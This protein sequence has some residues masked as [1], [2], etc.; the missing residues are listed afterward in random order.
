[1]LS[2]RPALL[3][4]FLA[5]VSALPACGEDASDALEGQQ[6]Q[7]WE[8]VPPGKADDYYSNVS[9][10]FEVSGLVQV[11]LDPARAEDTE[12]R[13]D[14]IER[15]ITAVSLFLTTYMTRKLEQFFSNTTYGG[16]GAM[17]RN[18]TVAAEDV[19]ELEPGL[20][21]V[22]FTVDVAGPR[23]LVDALPLV[24][25]SEEG[26]KAFVL[27]MPKGFEVDPDSVPRGQI[28]NFDPS[29]YAGEV[30]QLICDIEP[31]VAARDAYPQFAAM[32]EDGLLDLTLWY[33]HDYNES[34]SDLSEARDAFDELELLGFEAPVADFESLTPESGPFV[35][36]MSAGGQ[37]LQVEVRIFHS[38][39][40][41]GRRQDA[42]D[43]SLSELGLRDV[44]FYNG[45]AGPYY[46]FYLSTES[47]YDVRYQEFATV[48]LPEKQQIVVAQ[49]CQTYSQYADVFYANPAKSEANLDVFTTVNF[50]Y[51]QGTLG[52]LRNLLAADRD[53]RHKPTTYGKMVRDLNSE[54]WN[55]V[56]EV[57]YGV[58]GIDQNPRLHPYAAQ[59][60]IGRP[61]STVADCGDPYGNVCVPQGD[62]AEG[63]VCG[64]VALEQATCPE[65]SS[66]FALAQGGTIVN[67]ACLA[68]PSGE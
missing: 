45:H 52:L 47:A 46:G 56:K 14:K 32:T 18:H 25:G 38:D 33:G 19:R 44:F 31:E 58:H 39:M 28:R 37:A 67:Y 8:V 12:Y 17:A 7:P 9:A 6:E 49:G 66:V 59:D 55:S 63:W 36:Q 35:K 13:D 26:G 48:T 11:A 23:N 4:L 60:A 2:L 16:F 53:G 61:C 51:G 68:L 29:T 54:Y 43:L 27:A 5:A 24:E 20:L 42:H 41:V 57:F 34:R 65:G 30:E 62:P 21:E 50:S 3:L 15:R 40:F 22:R 64:A 1:M 10:E